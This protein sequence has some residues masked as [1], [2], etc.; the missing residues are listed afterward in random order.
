MYPVPVNTDD[1]AQLWQAQAGYRFREIGGYF[2]VPAPKGTPSGSQFFEPT[3]TTTALTALANGQALPRTPQLQA[4]LTAELG[5][6][7][8]SNVVVQPVGADPAGFFTWLIGRPPDA[9]TG[10]MLEWYGWPL[11]NRSR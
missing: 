6:W 11:P 2:V 7:G 10:G 3:P 9:A 5:A 4:Q 1:A 8:V